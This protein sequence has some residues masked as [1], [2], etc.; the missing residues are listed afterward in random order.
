MP[1]VA[2]LSI[3]SQRLYNTVSNYLDLLSTV[4]PMGEP[5]CSL[6]TGFIIRDSNLLSNNR[7]EF[8]RQHKVDLFQCT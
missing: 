1:V 7:E 5:E 2:H 4:R 3:F 8:I 6:Y